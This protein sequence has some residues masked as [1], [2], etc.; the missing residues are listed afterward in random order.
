MIDRRNVVAGSLALLATQRVVRAQSP[1]RT[2]RIGLLAWGGRPPDPDPLTLALVQGLRDGGYVLGQG[3]QP[4]F[5]FAEGRLERLLENAADLVS[6]HVDVIVVAGPAPVRAARSATSSIPIVMVGGS[7]DPVAE[8]LTTNLARPS[9]NITG[10]TYA[11]TPE[12]FGKELE[13][14]K[15]AVG[16]LSRIAVLW[17]AEPELYRRTLAP[18][19]GEAARGLGV[20]VPAPIVVT[21]PQALEAAFV[22]ARHLGADAVLLAT[23]GVLYAARESVGSLALRH[24]LPTMA[25]VKEFPLTGSLMSYGPDFIELFRR[26]G[27]YVTRILRGTKP[28]DLP[29]QQPSKF[30]LVINLKTAAALGLTIPQ[31]LLL[32]ASE[33]IR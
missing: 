20:D 2:V 24:R 25:A 14:L 33:L 5:R 29:I 9:G 1:S 16:R 23:G 13:L 15:T 26:S 17:D 18:P 21:S 32:Q 6:R 31:P 10:F 19:I 28:A 8:G 12:R 3:V 22:Q 7:S 11:A 4:D 27:E 30:D